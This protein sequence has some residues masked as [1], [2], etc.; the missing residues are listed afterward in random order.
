MGLKRGLRKRQRMGV[1]DRGRERG[2][3]KGSRMWGSL[4]GSSEL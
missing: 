3:G 2:Q 4:K 1:E